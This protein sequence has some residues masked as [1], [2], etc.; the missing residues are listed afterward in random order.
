MKTPD[1]VAC[2]DYLK[3]WDKKPARLS[4]V[5]CK[6]DSVA[7]LQVVKAE[8]VVSGRDAKSVE[9]A[10][11]QS[12]KM[13]PLVFRCC[14]WEPDQ[15]HANYIDAQKNYYEIHMTSGETLEKNWNAIEFFRVDVIRFLEMP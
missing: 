2:S 13:K 1:T 12:F 6:F 3:D 11:I 4:Y 8:Y 14:G 5:G 7:Q 15:P 9:N 10:F